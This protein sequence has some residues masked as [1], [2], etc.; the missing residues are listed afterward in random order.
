MKCFFYPHGHIVFNKSLKTPG[1]EI[2]I[3]FAH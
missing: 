3:F 2:G 1:G